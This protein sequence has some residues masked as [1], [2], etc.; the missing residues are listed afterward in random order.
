MWEGKKYA[1]FLLS[2][3]CSIITP[4]NT[5]PI[6]PL[7]TLPSPAPSSRVQCHM[8]PFTCQM[9]AAHWLRTQILFS[10]SF[11][12]IF[13]SALSCSALFCDWSTVCGCS[14]KLR[15]W[16]LVWRLF[17]RGDSALMSYTSGRVECMQLHAVSSA[18]SGLALFIWYIWCS[19]LIHIFLA[20]IIKLNTH[21]MQEASFSWPS[22]P[23][24]FIH[25]SPELCD[26]HTYSPM[27]R[28]LRRSCLFLF[29]ALTR[30]TSDAPIWASLQLYSRQELDWQTP[31]ALSFLHTQSG[32]VSTDAE[33]FCSTQKMWH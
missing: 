16:L 13:L 31:L 14:M 33:L 26:S 25:D 30:S 8:T 27:E 17:L 7:L 28:S 6:P 24:T 20:D 11:N 18:Y 15:I 2:S 10:Y 23:E 3:V 9:P 32:L 22:M 21:N 5:A 19:T 29:R 1:H 4:S 12:N